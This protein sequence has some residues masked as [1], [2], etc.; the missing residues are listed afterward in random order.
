[1]SYIRLNIIDQHQAINGEVH[2]SEGDAIVAALA[3]EPET[4]DELALAFS[5]FTQNR[6]ARRHQ[7]HALPR[8]QDHAP[9][10]Q[11]RETLLTQ[12]DAA[13]TQD[14]A[15]SLTQG[16]APRLTLR[17]ESL[18]LAQDDSLPLAR[19]DAASL[20]HHHES[21]FRGFANYENLEPSDAGV[22]IIDLA[23][24]LVAV[25]SSYSQPAAQGAIRLCI[26]DKTWQQ[27]THPHDEKTHEDFSD[28]DEK[29]QENFTDQGE[30]T[31]RDCADDQNEMMHE[32]F[33]NQDEKTHGDCANDQNEKS[34]KHFKDK[35]THHPFADYPTER[36]GEGE[37][38]SHPQT[39]RNTEADFDAELF[40]NDGAFL[41]EAAIA[42]YADDAPD[43]DAPDE[44]AIPYRLSDDWL[45]VYSIPEYESLCYQR[46]EARLARQ[47]LEARAVL[48][49]KPLLE[50]IARE[51]L[52]ARQLFA[53]SGNATAA[54]ETFA[55][56][57]QSEN[58]S[59]DNNE[60]TLAYDNEIREMIAAI[61]NPAES[62]SEA[63][64]EIISAIH[65]KWWM[66]Q[67]PDLQGK[68]PREV[69][70]AKHDFIDSDLHSRQLQWSFTNQCPPPLSTSSRA[71]LYGGFGRHEIV[72]YYDLVRHLLH[73]CFAYLQTQKELSTNAL[74]EFLEQTKT[75]W[76]A[77]PSR[78]YSGKIP[79]RYIE[80][81]RLRIPFAMSAQEAIIDE[82]CPLCRMSEIF[83]TPGFWH[84]DGSHMDNRFE[85][86]FYASLEEWQAEQ[87]EWE[88]SSKRF[89][90][91]W[92]ARNEK[93][94]P[95]KALNRLDDD[96][97]LIQ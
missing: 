62:V 9:S 36:F 25:D 8:T 47:P 14:H 46:R 58:L 26:G 42:F 56:A 84:L 22:V 6:E 96:E 53:E 2:G 70:L 88:E 66:T 44:I 54:E 43:D 81:E 72:V 55:Q 17:D 1:M 12:D 3:A 95:D 34:Q 18:P 45:F 91:D 85:F 52:A 87:Q 79:A 33:I 24:R 32:N 23:A 39:T 28:Q 51:G 13:L 92:Q 65:A 31:H 48:Y 37:T 4:I 93:P 11:D 5:R 35:K 7:D 68:T 71:Y 63:Q 77:M 74:S 83:D 38:L 61:S 20:A 10:V 80:L 67:R 97:T 90:R 16:D 27:S 78:D 29:I 19:N 94:S 40:N 89:E 21:P 60:E 41:D 30:K 82:D 64:W 59:S 73:E 76:L 69:L 86:S 50:F 49:G 75:F 57:E 15:S